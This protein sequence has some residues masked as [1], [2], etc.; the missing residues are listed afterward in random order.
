V[1]AG[2]G[3]VD[4]QSTQTG[5][6]NIRWI[7]RAKKDCPPPPDSL[8]VVRREL[9]KRVPLQSG[10][11]FAELGPFSVERALRNLDREENMTMRTVLALVLGS[12]PAG[13]LEAYD[14]T[15]TL[16]GMAFRVQ[17]WRPSLL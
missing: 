4:C 10:A 9:L 5:L 16:Q 17:H 12:P 13:A 3:F 11:G 2:T 14:Q 8:V 15:L 1:V 6:S 7:Y